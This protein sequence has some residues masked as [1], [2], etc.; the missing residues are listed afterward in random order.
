M[1]ASIEISSAKGVV[2]A[3]PSKSMAH[4]YLICAALSE[5]S[6][7]VNNIELSEDI[8]A[9]IDCI[10]AMGAE[11]EVKGDSVYVK[12]IT[13]IYNMPETVFKC[14]E[15]GSTLR[16]FIPISMLSGSEKCF[17]GSETLLK[18]P[19]S[20]YE[21]ICALQGID[22]KNDGKVV[23]VKGA[24]KADS[25]EIKGNISSQFISGL[26]FTLPLLNKDSYIRLIPPV[27]SRSYIDLTLMALSKFGVSVV[28]ED[29]NTLYIKGGQKY[30]SRE[31]ETEGDYSNA[32]FL[33]A[34]NYIGGSVEVTGLDC[35]SLQGDRVYREHFEALSRGNAT[36]DIS[37][38]PDLGPVLFTVAAVHHGGTFTGTRRLKIKESDRGAV[39]CTELLKFGIKSLQEEDSITI[40]ASPLKKPDETVC[41]HNDHRI[42][43]SMSLLLSLTGGTVDEAQAVRKSFPTFFECISKL[44]IE[45][46]PDGMD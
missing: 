40:Y 36:I 37:D 13:D 5:G 26:L 45:V 7:I 15:S 21:N 38:C 17:Y 44:G 16:F 12:G 18:R 43:M 29:E 3:P 23:S 33:D 34:F 30:V 24:L 31:I 46:K 9:T 4:R 2:K 19:L 10:K 42:V 41:G 22:F 1:N 25:F 39:M 14:R 28:W 20:V 32:A 35:E 8:K 6:S 27:D 11:C